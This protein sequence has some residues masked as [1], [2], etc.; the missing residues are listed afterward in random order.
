M[1]KKKTR[2]RRAGTTEACVVSS[3]L[4]IAPAS[5]D[6]RENS[7]TDVIAAATV[8][9]YE[10]DANAAGGDERGS[11]VAAIDENEDEAGDESF[12]GNVMILWH[13]CDLKRNNEE[14]VG[15]ESFIGNVILDNDND[16]ERNE[17]DW[18]DR[19]T[20]HSQ[21]KDEKGE[22]LPADRFLVCDV[23]GNEVPAIGEGQRTTRHSSYR[24]PKTVCEK[25]M[26][27]QSNDQL[28][29]AVV[30]REEWNH[31]LVGWEELRKESN[32]TTNR[33]LNDLSPT[34]VEAV[35]REEWIDG[36][37][38]VDSDGE[39]VVDYSWIG[40]IYHKIAVRSC[41][42]KRRYHPISRTID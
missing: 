6:E 34:E 32:R 38:V 36:D 4:A 2:R 22:A 11:S 27:T 33:T 19:G 24:S 20:S 3:V 31:P 29:R 17:C 16:L 7:F 21:V 35:G 18:E 40:K 13:H 14:E 41:I 42:C 12:I 37:W 26:K 8:W 15:E 23:D 10:K 1:A 28:S 39:S 25:Q 30:E 9:G 5:D